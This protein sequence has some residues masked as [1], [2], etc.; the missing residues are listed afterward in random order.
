MKYLL[1]FFGC[2]IQA[3]F[4]YSEYLK[5]PKQS[6][7]L[8]TCASFVFCLIAYLAHPQSS[9]GKLIL[10][11]LFFGMVGDFFLNLRYLSE[12]NAQKIFLIGILFFLIGHILY[13]C[14]IVPLSNNL[15]PCVLIGALL[16][17]A[18]LCYI[19]KT[20][21]VKPAFK[22]FGVFY[23]GAIIIMTVIAVG[24][25]LNIGN[26]FTVLYAL[27]AILFTISDII[28]IFNTFGKTSRFSLRIANLSFYY[29][30]QLLI[31]L[32]VYYL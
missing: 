20:M 2:L 16:A 30:G 32:S 8:K 12:N 1:A 3:A 23:L 10:Y 4:I 7:I 6:L 26:A 27:G 28:L 21:E 22:I 17:A 24:N 19:F 29:I 5:K 18:L 31:A 15:L 13:L 11:G 25:W 14:A 9:I